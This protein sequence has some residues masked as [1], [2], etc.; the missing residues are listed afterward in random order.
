MPNYFETTTNLE[1][2]EYH[3]FKQ[4]EKNDDVQKF[5]SG[6]YDFLYRYYVQWWRENIMNGIH[7][8]GSGDENF[9]YFF[10]ENI[11]GIKSIWRYGNIAYYDTSTYDSGYPWDKENFTN[12]IL[13]GQFVQIVKW[14]ISVEYGRFDVVEFYNFIEGPFFNYKILNFYQDEE[15][16]EIFHIDL[17]KTENQ[18][19]LI[20]E[21]LMREDSPV[22]F[23]FGIKFIINFV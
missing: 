4:Y 9:L 22:V 2:P 23:P 6:V 16:L 20:V 18:D 11:Y 8:V 17:D 15:K 13:F 21:L 5:F 19:T 1:I 3:V 10:C 14:N 12:K 7:S